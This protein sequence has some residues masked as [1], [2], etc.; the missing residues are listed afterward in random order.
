MFAGADFAIRTDGNHSTNQYEILKSR[1]QTTHDRL[2]MDPPPMP[3]RARATINLMSALCLHRS[4]SP[5]DILSGSAQG[6]ED[7]KEDDRHLESDL[8]ACDVCQS[9]I[10]WCHDC[11]R[12]QVGCPD[13]GV[14]GRTGIEIG[15]DCW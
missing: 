3:D 9:P 10:D 5:S 4:S 14:L 12:K 15:R 7:E 13:P 1:G 6:R 8:T 11:L 2:M